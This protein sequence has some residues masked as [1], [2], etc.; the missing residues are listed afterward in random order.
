MMQHADATFSVLH[1]FSRFDMYKFTKQGGSLFRRSP[2]RL[3]LDS[4]VYIDL[5]NSSELG[6]DSSVIAEFNKKTVTEQE[7]IKAS[8]ADLQKDMESVIANYNVKSKEILTSLQANYDSMFQETEK[9]EEVS[10]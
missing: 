8:I 6:N 5:L 1:N 7:V 10:W 4:L 2:A 3:L 9:P